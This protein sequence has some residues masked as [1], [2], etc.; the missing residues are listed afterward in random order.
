M[1]QKSKKT[2]INEI[3]SKPPKRN[4]ATNKTDVFHID[5]TWSLDILDLKDYGPGNNRGYRYVLVIKNSFSK[6]GFTIPL[7]NKNAQTIK[8]SF[9][10]IVIIS[11]RKPNLFE[12]DRG[13][14]FYND[15]FQGFLYNN[16]I[17]LCSWNS[18]Y[19]AFFVVRCNRTIRNLLKRPDFEENDGIRSDLLPVVTK[20][21]NNRIHTS[22]KLTPIQACLKRDEI[23]VYK[24][25]LDK[26]NK[27]KPKFQANDLVRTT[28]LK[29]TCSKGFTTKWSFKLY[30]ITETINDTIPSYKIDNLKKRYNEAL[31]KK[32]ELKMKENISV[33]EK[34]NLS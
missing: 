9:K 6:I 20:Q 24:S 21:Y 16:N 29:K 25:L 3:Y 15:N 14:E 10:K 13:K 28:E 11:K 31:L 34:L 18:S 4:Y 32:P 23:Y 22:T 12:S 8:D 7:R 19:G 2:F 5:N 26:R 17:K 1:T 30:K 27:V 33:I